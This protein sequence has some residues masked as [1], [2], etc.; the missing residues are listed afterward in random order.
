MHS[1][2]VNHSLF[3]VITPDL[4]KNKIT[5]FGPKVQNI[6]IKVLFVLGV[7]DLDFQ[8]QISLQS[9]ILPNRMAW[10]KG[11]IIYWHIFHSGFLHICNI[12]CRLD[13]RYSP[14][15]IFNAKNFDLHK[16]PMSLLNVPIP[17]VCSEPGGQKPVL[18]LSL[19]RILS[20]KLIPWLLHGP[21]CF[22]VSILCSPVSPKTA[23]LTE[24][25]HQAHGGSWNVI[26]VAWGTLRLLHCQ[27]IGY[28]TV[29]Q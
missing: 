25:G 2:C 4:F 23:V 12:K 20:C 16:K 22:T 8:G 19:D 5:K 21:D 15:N 10:Q 3:H 28:T 17:R 9:Q 7:I 26:S 27:G 18:S 11:I 24:A 13:R 1:P 29:L 6:F 14:Q